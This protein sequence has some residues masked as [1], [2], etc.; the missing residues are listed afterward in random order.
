MLRFV[1]VR[2]FP[3]LR[4]NHASDWGEQFFDGMYLA[5]RRLRRP[6][7]DQASSQGPVTSRRRA[8]VLKPKQIRH[9]VKGIRIACKDAACAKILEPLD[10]KMKTK[11]DADS[12]IEAY[13]GVPPICVL[14]PVPVWKKPRRWTTQVRS[15]AV[16]GGRPQRSKALKP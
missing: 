14:R 15:Q 13:H 16:R 6:M 8:H 4:A 3:E 5:S 11:I 12:A 10:L 1:F 7:Y 2:G 9:A